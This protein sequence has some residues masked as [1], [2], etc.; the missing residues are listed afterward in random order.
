MS[1]EGTDEEYFLREFT[2]GG[3][4]DGSDEM[5]VASRVGDEG[6]RR[7]R[8]GR[9]VVEELKIVFICVRKYQL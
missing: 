5:I 1:K 8:T 2:H 4:R 3:D 7:F 9:V 6:S